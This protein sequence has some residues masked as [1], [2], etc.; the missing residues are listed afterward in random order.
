[1]IVT[2]RPIGESEQRRIRKRREE[3]EATR[4]AANRTAKATPTIS[5]TSRVA[6]GGNAGEAD[7]REEGAQTQR[8][9]GRETTQF[10]IFPG[11]ETPKTH[12]KTL[13][14]HN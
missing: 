6:Q 11:R 13:V 4:F 1:M 14:V 10:P 12:D 5:R 2:F 9:V 3:I 7:F 8:V